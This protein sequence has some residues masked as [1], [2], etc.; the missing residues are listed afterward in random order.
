[1]S[2]DI[3]YRPL[4]FEDVLGQDAT[5]TI[6]RRF[7]ATG[8][9]RHQS[10]LIAGPYGSGNTTVGRILARS[11]LCEQPSDEGDP[12]D[13]C[14]SCL[15][16]LEL[17]SSMDFTEVDAATNSGKAEIQKITEEIQY[18]SFTGR[19]RIYL[20]DEAHQLSASALDAMLKPLEEHQQG[21]ED[22]KL[23]CIFCTTEPEKMRATIFSRCAPAF[24]IHPVTPEEIADRMSFICDKEGIEYE[25][26]ML[27]T[28]AEM[29]E[30]HIRDSL[31]AIEGIS[32]LGSINKENVV[33]YL[34]LD[35]TQ[36]YLDVLEGI[37][38]DQAKAI[39]AV[40]TVLLKTSPVV[41]YERLTQ[42]AILAY[43]IHLGVLNP[44]AHIDADRIRAIG[45]QHGEGLLRIA[46][47][48][49]SRPRK[50]NNA[51]L[52][53]DV[54]ILHH[55]KGGVPVAHVSTVQQEVPVNPPPQKT[56]VSPPPAPKSGHNPSQ[57]GKMT[58]STGEPLVLRGSK[59]VD[60]L[61]TIKR[62]TPAPE[63][64]GMFA[65]ILRQAIVDARARHEGSS[66]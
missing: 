18:D 8:R 48:F 50:P 44:P 14:S 1:M 5:I 27:V 51:M 36:A 42:L 60:D 2:L 25:K 9:G 63:T 17:G 53:C 55:G 59:N 4:R 58:T 16:I 33:S 32:M 54:G 28:L 10:Y 15:S 41:C 61:K 37:G 64:N 31:K 40:K 43:Q 20:F 12:C 21:T 24:I 26:E 62:A 23:V 6:L 30:C 34:H 56:G 47:Q 13:K 3:K 29:T 22:K 11:L 46:H 38:Q 66:R 39:A 52:L 19:Q 35:L 45:H 49:A 57:G 7:V 65:N